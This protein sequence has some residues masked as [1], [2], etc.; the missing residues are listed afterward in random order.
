M[1]PAT[2][3]QISYECTPNYLQKPEVPKRIYEYKKDIKLLLI[4]KDP[5]ERLI[6]DYTHN[7][8]HMKEKSKYPSKGHE[9]QGVTVIALSTP[10][11][12]FLNRFLAKYIKASQS[13][14]RQCIEIPI[15]NVF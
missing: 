6:S 14:R 10:H 5:V 2:S 7:A 15:W 13:S 3:E 1:N 11:V 9:G 4:L 12:V 8:I